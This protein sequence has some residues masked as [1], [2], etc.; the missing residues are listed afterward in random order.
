MADIDG[1]DDKDGD[2]EEDAVDHNEDEGKDDDGNDDE[3]YV[4]DSDDEG[5]PAYS[6]QSKSHHCGV[7]TVVITVGDLSPACNNNRDILTYLWAYFVR[8]SGI[9]QAY[10]RHIYGISWACLGH[11]LGLP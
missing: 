2:D 1:G 11:M 4:I 9:F 3:S 10:L 6:H 8:N 5:S 7:L